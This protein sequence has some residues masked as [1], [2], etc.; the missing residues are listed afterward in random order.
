MSLLDLPTVLKGR[1]MQLLIRECRNKGKA[2][3]KDSSTIKQSPSS[4][5]R[6]IHNNLIHIFELF[7]RN[8]S[9]WKMGTAGSDPRLVSPRLI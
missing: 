7:Y 2:V 3:K 4:S 1:F 5:S 8:N 6:D 9:R